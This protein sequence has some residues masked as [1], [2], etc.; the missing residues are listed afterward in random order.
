[1]GRTHYEILGVSKDFTPEEL[2]TAYRR[3]S[4]TAHPDVG[5][6]AAIFGMV[7]EAYETLR[8]PLKRSAYDRALREGAPAPEPP[9]PPPPPK[10]SPK[11]PPPRAPRASDYWQPKQEPS[12]PTPPPPVEE[13]P[14]DLPSNSIPFT[15]RLLYGVG[16]VVWVVSMDYTRA[17]ERYLGLEWVEEP[18]MSSLVFLLSDPWSLLWWFA[19]GAFGVAVVWEGRRDAHPFPWWEQLLVA[20]ALA[21]AVPL[22]TWWFSGWP[23]F[24]VLVVA[25]TAY[26]L[27]T[28]YRADGRHPDREP[29]PDSVRS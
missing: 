3:I 29:A 10:A 4:R 17:V 1:M 25:I 16:M 23:Q 18:T 21:F 28:K 12:R 22:G 26:S 5:G 13:T 8:E 11:P 7:Q 15:H 2:K 9:S 19:I 14:D 27:I 24:Y 20:V 6:S